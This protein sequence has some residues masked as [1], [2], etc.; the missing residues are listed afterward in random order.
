M[1]KYNIKHL[2]IT[3]IAMRR[4]RLIT[5]ERRDYFCEGKSAY[6][7]ISLNDDFESLLEDIQRGKQPKDEVSTYFLPKLTGRDIKLV[8]NNDPEYLKTFRHEH[9]DVDEAE[10]KI[11]ESDSKFC[12]THCERRTF[13]IEHTAG[14]SWSDGADERPFFDWS[15]MP[16]VEDLINKAPSPPLAIEYK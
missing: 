3:F 1:E 2:M 11:S 9:P 7:K 16:P 6:Y 4:K 8:A 5:L 14:Q 15:K 12:H 13:T 10:M